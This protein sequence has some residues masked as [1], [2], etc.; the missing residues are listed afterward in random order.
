MQSDCH[1]AL[2]FTPVVPSRLIFQPPGGVTPD[3][4]RITLKR[5]MRDN[6][7]EVD[8]P[9]IACGVQ[10]MVD[11]LQTDKCF[12][13][14]TYKTVSGQRRGSQIYQCTAAS[15]CSFRLRFKERNIASGLF[16]SQV[17]D[18]HNKHDHPA[19]LVMDHRSQLKQ[20]LPQ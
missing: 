20:G 19:D 16:Y 17:S 9:V 8:P 1:R 14:Y 15:Q 13:E 18:L 10:Q 4:T 11:M 5:R 6:Y 12:G 3:N 2:P 7:T